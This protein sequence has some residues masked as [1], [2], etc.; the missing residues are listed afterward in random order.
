MLVAGS[1]ASCSSDYLDL[2]PVTSI[3]TSTVTGSTEG[4]RQGIY[5]ICNSMFFIYQNYSTQFRFFTGEASLMTFYGEVPSPD[6]FSWEWARTGTDFMNWEYMNRNQ[7]TPAYAGWT[8]CY[9]LIN[10][11]NNILSGIDEATG[12][13]TERD[14]I[15]AQALTFRAHAYTQLLRLYGPR[16]ADSRNGE[17]YALVERLVPG[18]GDAPL[19][20][21]NRTLEQIYTD[22][23]LAIQLYQS[24]GMNRSHIWEPNIDVARGIYARAAILKEDWATAQKM[25]HD[26]RAS[27]PIMSADEYRQGFVVANGEYMWANAYDDQICGYWDWGTINACNG[28]YVSFWGNGSGCISYDLIRQLS[29]D[30]IRLNMYWTPRADLSK[31]GTV[32]EALFFNEGAVNVTNMDC[33]TNVLMKSSIVAMGEDL[34]K[35]VYGSED[36]NFAMPYTLESESGAASSIIVPFGAHFK[37][38]GNGVYSISQFPFM[39]AAELL[40]LEA[41]AAFRQNDF[42]TTHSCLN[43]LNANRHT[44]PYDCSSLSGEQLWD[45]LMLSSRIELWGEGHTWF[46]MKRWAVNAERRPWVAGDVNSNNIPTI[47]RSSHTPDAEN[48]WR[49]VIPYQESNTNKAVDLNL[50]NY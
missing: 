35:N 25:A 9:N 6:Y 14:F 32:S 22:L 20:T 12:S 1:L 50:L 16:W 47:Y 48:G 30:D 49:W 23:D 7:Y 11:A 36:K 19:V 34:A 40:L 45:E 43:E 3:D 21:M 29:D 42:N 28:A 10:Q 37:F 41:E 2:E 17:K 27:Y 24:S 44:D 46:N 18:T 5:G 38:F 8:Y 31:Y 26:A 33:N 4:A 13:E 15:K 39:R